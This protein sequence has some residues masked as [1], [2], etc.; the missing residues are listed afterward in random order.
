MRVR[1]SVVID[2]DPFEFDK[3]HDEV[4]Y[5]EIG[6]ILKNHPEIYDVDEFKIELDDD[7]INYEDMLACEARRE[8]DRQVSEYYGGLM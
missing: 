2:I 7:D 8:Q 1:A 3:T 6:H 4:S 5:P